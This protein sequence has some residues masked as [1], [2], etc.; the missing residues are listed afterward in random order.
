MRLRRHEQLTVVDLPNTGLISP[1]NSSVAMKAKHQTVIDAEVVAVEPR[2]ELT[3]SR[4]RKPMPQVPAKPPL[5]PL[6]HEPQATGERASAQSLKEQSSRLDST[7]G[8]SPD[9]LRTS[10][11]RFA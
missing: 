10:D 4:Q 1:L 11:F 2:G 6:G 8:L 7:S 3:L 9:Q 5:A